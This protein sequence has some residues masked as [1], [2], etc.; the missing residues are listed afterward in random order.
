MTVLSVAEC[1]R[2]EVFLGNDGRSDVFK[3]LFRL[4]EGLKPFTER[5]TPANNKN[6][7]KHDGS[8]ILLKNTYDDENVWRCFL[9]LLIRIVLIYK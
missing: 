1:K 2:L 9:M 8:I 5:K 7:G 3:T 4:I 6:E